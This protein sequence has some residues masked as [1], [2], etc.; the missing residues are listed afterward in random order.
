[1]ENERW[2]EPARD[3]VPAGYEPPRV[4]EVLNTDDL[5]REVHYAGVPVSPGD[6]G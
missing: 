2:N 1:M 5:A 3:G 4:E 6:I